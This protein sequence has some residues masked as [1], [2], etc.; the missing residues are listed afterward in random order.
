VVA[1]RL[2]A[3]IE[4]DD[5]LG[6]DQ[7][8]RQGARDE[9]PLR[10]VRMTDADMTVGVDHLLPRQDAVGDHQ[11]ADQSVEAAHG[12]RRGASML[13]SRAALWPRMARRSASSR[14]SQPSTK[15]TGSTSPISAG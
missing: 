13:S 5:V 14:P 6:T 7:V 8:R 15:P 2:A 12:S 10:V 3:E 9:E 11:I 4:F 1:H